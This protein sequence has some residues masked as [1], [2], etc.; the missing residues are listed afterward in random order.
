MTIATTS[1]TTQT[2]EMLDVPS[3]SPTRSTTAERA[4]RDD[5]A[6]IPNA[7]RS[8]WTKLR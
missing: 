5:V 8:E 4:R 7:L 1:I 3:A 6:A 2:T